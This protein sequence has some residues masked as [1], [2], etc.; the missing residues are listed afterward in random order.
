MQNPRRSLQEIDH[1]L[2]QLLPERG[3][4]HLL[5][6]L[7]LAILGVLLSTSCHLNRIAVAIA[8]GHRT[9][10]IL[11]RLRRWIARD[12]FV[13]D[14]VLVELA[15]RFI[16]ASGTVPL[17]LV[18]DRT[19][20]KHANL[21]MVG[22]AFRG[23]AIPVAVTILP[24]PKATHANELHSVLTQAA[25]VLTP[26]ADVVVVGDREFGNIPAIRVIRRLGWH[27]C[28]RFKEDTWFF[29]PDGSSWQ[30]RRAFPR[31]GRRALWPGVRV[32]LQQYGL[33]NAAVAWGKGEDR[34]WVLVSDLPASALRVIYQRRMRIEEMFSDLKKR[35]F[36]LEATR[37]RDPKRI[38]RLAAL[39]CIVYLWLLIVALHTIRRGLRR[40]VDPA[41]RRALSYFQIALRM[42]KY[43]PPEAVE[44]LL[45]AASRTIGPK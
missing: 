15:G 12:T 28:F 31:R 16:P 5:K 1:W 29:G 19:E 26:Q 39:L 2:R 34:P 44:P 36:H 7:P 22:V 13:V 6:F 14:Q 17:T 45:K 40:F 43:Q 27:F 32:T 3:H 8:F 30:A 42:L 20:W 38:L 11:Q 18:V 35:G 4:K 21:L 41:K 24:G 23:R 33:L 10:S 9:A 37:L 25:Q